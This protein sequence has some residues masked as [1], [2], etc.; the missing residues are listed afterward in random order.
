[1]LNVYR[2]WLFFLAKDDD[3]WVKE[4]WVNVQMRWSLKNH[5]MNKEVFM[6]SYTNDDTNKP[7]L[8]LFS[9]FQCNLWCNKSLGKESRFLPQSFF[10]ILS[11]DS[12][13][14]TARPHVESWGEILCVCLQ[15]GHL[16]WMSICHSLPFP[17]IPSSSSSSLNDKRVSQRKRITFVMPFL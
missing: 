6:F 7:F 2:V 9:C 15:S 4:K 14:Q 13:K 8:L 10:P 3:L 11:S 5:L 1:M 12:L 17:C 16:T